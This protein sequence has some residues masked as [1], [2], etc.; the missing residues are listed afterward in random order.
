MLGCRLELMQEMV[1]D[2]VG[3]TVEAMESHMVEKAK[4]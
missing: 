1:M 4:L 3:E 2:L